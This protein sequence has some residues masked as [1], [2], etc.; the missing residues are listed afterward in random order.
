MEKSYATEALKEV[1]NYLIKEIGIE[2]LSAEFDSLNVASGKILEKVG[3]QKQK[4]EYGIKSKQRNI[5][6]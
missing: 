6:C 4:E 2:Q 5:R 3:M 1:I